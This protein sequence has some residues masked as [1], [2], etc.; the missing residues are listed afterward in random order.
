MLALGNAGGKGGLP[1]TAQGTI[2]APQPVDQGQRQRRQHHREAARHARDRRADPGGRLRRPAG[3]RQRP[4]RRH[5]H[6]RQRRA[7]ARTAPT[8]PP[9]R[10]SRSRSTRPSPSP[11]RS[12]RAR[13]PPP[14]TSAWPASWASTS[15]TP[16]KP[17]DCGTATRAAAGGFSPA[18]SSGALVCDVYPARPRRRPAWRRRRDHLGHSSANGL[19]NRSSDTPATGRCTSRI[20]AHQHLTRGQRSPAACVPS[21]AQTSE[22]APGTPTTVHPQAACV[23]MVAPGTM[24]STAY[25]RVPSVRPRR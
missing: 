10:A 14:C 22:R 18:V 23:P 24:R 1:S 13:P 12:T 16:S 11:T 5:G 4:G 21:S 25:R 7:R 2:Q 17:T 6:R 3:Q 9:P 20:G 19:T 15:P 8:R